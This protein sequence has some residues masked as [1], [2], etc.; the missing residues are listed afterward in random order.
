MHA[1]FLKSTGESIEHN[2]Y[3]CYNLMFKV[4]IKSGQMETLIKEV[5]SLGLI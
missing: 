4:F 5:N 2:L 3:L 1:N